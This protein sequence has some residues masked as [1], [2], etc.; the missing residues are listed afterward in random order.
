[1]IQIAPSILAAD[2][3]KLGEE[4]KR[5]EASGAD[6]IHFDVMDGHFVSNLSFG[7][8][9][10][11]A[12][13]PYSKLP[14]DVHL[15]VTNPE[16]LIAPFAEAGADSITIHVEATNH[17]DGLL[18]EI[19]R[20]GK[21]CGVSLNPGTPLNTLENILS[22]TDIILIMSVNPGMGGQKYISGTT[23]KI[24]KLS[25]LIK[26]TQNEVSIH[27]DGGIGLD[28]VK[29]VSDAGAN[30]LVTGSSFFSNQDTFK[31]ISAMKKPV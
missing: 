23:D 31:F 6:R 26:K 19:K 21:H 5:I 27:V 9:I 22:L 18:R 2:F 16:C 1:M 11:A 14:M 8:M 29:I 10:L 17:V 7:A 25:E 3:A 12:I 13:R 28:N 20:L 30:V 15:M 4:V 24:A